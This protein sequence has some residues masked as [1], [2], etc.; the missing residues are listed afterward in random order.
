MTNLLGA[1]S[2]CF[3]QGMITIIIISW[4]MEEGSGLRQ[5]H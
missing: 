5:L 2:L 4:V 3:I 1:S